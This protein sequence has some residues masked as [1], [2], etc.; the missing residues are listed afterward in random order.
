MLIVSCIKHGRTGGDRMFNLTSGGM[1][2]IAWHTV[3][4]PDLVRFFGEG[5]LA[6]L[7]SEL[8]RD[9]GDGLWLLTPCERFEDWTVNTWCEGEAAIIDALG[10]DCF[11][12]PSTSRQPERKPSLPEFAPYPVK[13]ER[14]FD[15]GKTWHWEFLNGYPSPE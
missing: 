8:A 15:D 1:S 14:S 7:P 3:L 11:F 9:L 5:A 6:S 4:G 10:V 12:D 13:V 2:G